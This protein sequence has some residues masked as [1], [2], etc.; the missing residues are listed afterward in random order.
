MGQIGPEES[1]STIVD[2]YAA[3]RPLTGQIGPGDSLQ[4]LE[5]T[6][7]SNRRTDRSMSNSLTRKVVRGQIGPEASHLTSRIIRRLISHREDR[8]VL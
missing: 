3:D 4:N 5:P 2:D 8:L 6:H 7:P 1:Q